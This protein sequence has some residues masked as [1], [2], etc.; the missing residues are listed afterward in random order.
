MPSRNQD[1]EIT[2]KYTK[3]IRKEKGLLLLP[4]SVPSKVIPFS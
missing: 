3:K 2:R 4:E 1:H